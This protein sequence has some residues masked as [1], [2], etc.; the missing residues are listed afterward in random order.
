MKKMI[1]SVAL[2]ALATGP[3]LAQAT[4]MLRQTAPAYTSPRAFHDGYAARYNSYAQFGNGPVVVESNHIVGQ[5]P[6]PNVRLQ[7]KRDPVSDY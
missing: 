1:L 5:D 6:D 3:A 7:L 2:A 4:P